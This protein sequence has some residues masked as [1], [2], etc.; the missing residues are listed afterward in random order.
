MIIYP[1]AVQL[2]LKMSSLIFAYAD[3]VN[4]LEKCITTVEKIIKRLP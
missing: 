1:P 3:D 2:V 4:L